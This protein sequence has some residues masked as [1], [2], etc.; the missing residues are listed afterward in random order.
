M[1]RLLLISSVLAVLVFAGC[2]LFGGSSDYYPLTV[3][4]AWNQRAVTIIETTDA[5]PETSLVTENR[6]VIIRKDTLN[7]GLD[8]FVMAYTTTMNFRSPET[9]YTVYDTTFIHEADN[10]VL[11]FDAKTDSTADTLLSLPLGPGKAW[12]QGIAVATVA[13]QE[14]VTVAAGTYKN[15]WRIDYIVAVQ[16][17]VTMHM[18]YGNK[19]GEVKTETIFTAAGYRSTYISELTSVIIE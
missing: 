19:I 15:C 7:S 3:G 11:V 18:W 8:V 2:D 9:T 4:N 6:M 17:G 5:T 12:V 10:A 13:Q 1:K 16:P 14:N